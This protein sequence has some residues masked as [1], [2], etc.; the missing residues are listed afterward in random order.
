MLLLV[1]LDFVGATW[2]RVVSSRAESPVRQYI[3]VSTP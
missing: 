3:T 1:A 2:A